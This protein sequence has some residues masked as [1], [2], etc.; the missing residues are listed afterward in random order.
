MQKL[1]NDKVMQS[2]A[3]SLKIERAATP[4]RDDL[5]KEQSVLEVYLDRQITN[6]TADQDSKLEI[7]KEKLR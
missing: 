4:D 6:A 1:E 3:M 7:R 5:V 2:A